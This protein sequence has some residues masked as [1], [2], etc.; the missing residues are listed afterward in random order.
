[1]ALHYAP[2]VYVET[3]RPQ[4]GLTGVRMDVPGFIGIAEKGPV[5]SV[6]A[7]DGW[8]AFLDIFGDFQPNAFLAYSVRSFFE[9]G[10]RRCHVVR[11]AADEVST[12]LD[13]GVAQPADGSSS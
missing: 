12:G 6:V 7:L 2:G 3:P 10:G 1:M 4:D 5:D 8:P 9:N 13:L 11:V